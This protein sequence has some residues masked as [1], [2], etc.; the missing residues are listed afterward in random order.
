[1]AIHVH[2]KWAVVC[3]TLAAS[4]RAARAEESAWL[5]VDLT[6]AM[7]NDLIT[8][9]IRDEGATVSAE[10]DRVFLTIPFR[11][12]L[13]AAPRTLTRSA[14]RARE[15]RG[16][17]GIR[18]LPEPLGPI[19]LALLDEDPLYERWELKPA[20]GRP[21][22]TVRNQTGPR[23]AEPDSRAAGGRGERR[24]LR[25]MTIPASGMSAFVVEITNESNRLTWTWA[26]GEE[27]TID[28][29]AIRKAREPLPLPPMTGPAGAEGP[30]NGPRGAV[31]PML[32]DVINTVKNGSAAHA[33]LA[34]QRLARA[35]REWPARVD[36]A[37]LADL[38]ERMLEAGATDRAA[39]RAAAW[40]YFAEPLEGFAPA[41]WIAPSALRRLAKDAAL[42]KSWLENV[43]H[44]LG[45]REGGVFWMGLVGDERSRRGLAMLIGTNVLS[46]TDAALIDAAGDLLLSLGPWP[47]AR[48]EASSGAAVGGAGSEA[49]GVDPNDPRAA[50]KPVEL[51][52]FSPAALEA[53]MKRLPAIPD[54]PWATDLIRRLVPLA[55]AKLA[56]ALA[57]ELERRRVVLSGPED[58]LLTAWGSLRT[59]GQRLAMVTALNRLYVG[60]LVYSESFARIWRDATG[61]AAS[62]KVREA[63][64]RLLLRIASEDLAPREPNPFPVIVLLTSHDPLVDAL[65]EIVIRMKSADGA[66]GGEQGRSAR[67]RP[68][69]RETELC[70]AAAEQ[71]LRRGL[72]E[73]AARLVAGCPPGASRATHVETL[74]RM[75]NPPADPLAAFAGFLLRQETIDCV[76]PALE[77]LSRRAGA[78]PSDERWRLLA[79]LRAGVH[80]GEL[81]ALGR[82][83]KGAQAVAVRR[84]LHELGHMTQQDR[85][86]LAGA[87]DPEQRLERLKEIDFRRGTAVEG[88]Y[89]ALAVVETV[90]ARAG[91]ADAE[92]GNPSI[93]WSL[94]TRWT[95]AL[96]PIDLELPADVHEK[97]DAPYRVLLGK[98]P[99]GE[100]RI[101]QRPGV[102][103]SPATFSIAL[104]SA[105][106]DGW[107]TTNGL[108]RGTTAAPENAAAEVGP[109]WMVARPVLE[110][111]LA[112]TMTIDAA[113]LLK[114]AIAQDQSIGRRVPPARVPEKLPIT[115]RHASFGSFYGAA[116]WPGELPE[117]IPDGF[118]RPRVVMI[119]LERMD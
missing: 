70:H 20:A 84:W 49:V 23:G 82:A 6:P 102:L 69:S 46:G 113:P 109:L 95:I 103:G 45:R 59:D 1:M 91:S 112:G 87:T 73:H 21:T 101:A 11:Y 68:G 54:S 94:P 51:S 92:S 41:D 16:V 28:L 74:L 67:T 19:D 32:M 36:P 85:Q 61:P 48:G 111:P 42:Q 5:Y 31:A 80:P 55:P 76:K 7:N 9:S 25:S 66:S 118:I 107:A 97:P 35:R 108:L 83:L 110:K 57:Q 39:V 63:T 60:E 98:A 78:E 64:V 117:S 99:L 34:V 43:E 77:Y 50:D 86:R 52:R 75:K 13:G 4:D 24:P 116:D 29:S 17:W 30:S 12:D 93:S 47:I 90:T 81:D 26:N 105:P 89:G 106:W 114:R 58:P 115:L 38:D 10:A 22:V 37:F 62:S 44:G 33:A 72:A 8:P 88:R 3:L 56:D 104:T 96:P 18:L 15:F 100:G 27:E 79:A 14:M 65:S 53:L 40:S 71:L 119:V 2:W